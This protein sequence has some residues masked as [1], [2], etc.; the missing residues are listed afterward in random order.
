MKIRKWKDWNSIL[1]LNI[2]QCFF[3]KSINFE[4]YFR[5]WLGFEIWEFYAKVCR[6]FQEVQM[7]LVSVNL[8]VAVFSN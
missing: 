4:N 3:N 6:Q 2:L 1:L 7:W 5:N 8:K